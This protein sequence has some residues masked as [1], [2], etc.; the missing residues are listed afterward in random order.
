MRT[1]LRLLGLGLALGLA[2]HPATAGD[3][4]RAARPATAGDLKDL[5]FGEALYHAYQGDWFQSIA[6][7]DTE[8]GQH[9]RVDEPGLDGV[10]DV[11]ARQLAGKPLSNSQRT[12]SCDRSGNN[13]ALPAFA[14]PFR[15]MH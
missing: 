12:T 5:F 3:L 4:G 11:P 6:R 2:A 8:L 14:L 9:R 7:L 15:V 13:D 1:T 10:L